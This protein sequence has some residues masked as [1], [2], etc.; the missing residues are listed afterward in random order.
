MEDPHLPSVLCSQLLAQD[1]LL[2]PYPLQQVLGGMFAPFLQ[3]RY[4]A[5]VD[6][7]VGVEVLEGACQ[8]CAHNLAPW[9]SRRENQPKR[10]PLPPQALTISGREL[11]I[12]LG[13]R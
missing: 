4:G 6:P 10:T 12:A 7:V 1:A 2:L 3:D 13:G 8:R 5:A 11:R 9:T